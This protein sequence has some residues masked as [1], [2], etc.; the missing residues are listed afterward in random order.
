VVSL[1]DFGQFS[2]L[3]LDLCIICDRERENVLYAYPLNR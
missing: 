3:R 2:S 1:L